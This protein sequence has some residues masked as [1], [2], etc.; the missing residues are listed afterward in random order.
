VSVLER[1]TFS[2]DVLPSRESGIS[3]RRFYRRLTANNQ[4]ALMSS[5]NYAT[6]GHS[7][8]KPYQPFS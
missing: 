2:L 8:S 1:I 7:A 5:D 4:T 3:T 6:K